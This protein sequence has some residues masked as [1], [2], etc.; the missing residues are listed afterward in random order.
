MTTAKGR[1]DVEGNEHS[2]YEIT[3]R[4]DKGDSEMRNLEV[5]IYFVGRGVSQDREICDEV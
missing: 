2:A 4:R 3:G 5:M 1:E